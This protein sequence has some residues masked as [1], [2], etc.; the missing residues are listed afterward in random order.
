MFSLKGKNAIVTGAGSGIG[1]AIAK[2]LAEQGAVVDI[3]E[4]DMDGAAETVSAIETE[5]GT[6]TAHE[7]DV[8]NQAATLSVFEEIVD[9]RGSL[10]GLVNNAGIAH[11]GNVL[12][13][14]EEDYEHVMS[15]N[16]KGVYNCLKAGVTHMQATGGAIVNMSSRVG[17]Y[18]KPARSAYAASKFALDGVTVVTV[19][20]VDSLTGY[21]LECRDI[22]LAELRKT[23]YEG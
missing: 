22:L 18:G 5:G 3:L 7:C 12:T 16:A 1:Q 19:W 13:T 2:V 4:V 14:T 6:A 23:I 8:T 11:V 21:E 9:K 15:V 10:D 17:L 20:G